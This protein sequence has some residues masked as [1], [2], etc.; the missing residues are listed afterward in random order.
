MGELQKRLERLFEEIGFELAGDMKG[1][2]PDALKIVEEAKKEYPSL[3]SLGLVPKLSEED[4]KKIA[5][6][7]NQWFER[8][9]GGEK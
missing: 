3:L 7:R 6:A 2:L 9:F 5:I 8:W 4:I 1:S